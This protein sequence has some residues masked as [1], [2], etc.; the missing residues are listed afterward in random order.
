MIQLLIT[1]LPCPSSPVA[2][3]EMGAKA[4]DDG[5]IWLPKLEGCSLLLATDQLENVVAI[6]KDFFPK[7]QT[8]EKQHS[9]TLSTAKPHKNGPPGLVGESRKFFRRFIRRAGAMLHGIEGQKYLLS[10]GML[11]RWMWLWKSPVS[12]FF[13][14]LF[15]IN[16]FLTA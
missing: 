14:G 6:D 16:P 1:S 3:F 7:R 13:W 9:N 12:M 5:S 11:T 10:V 2:G 8:T 4:I 15:R